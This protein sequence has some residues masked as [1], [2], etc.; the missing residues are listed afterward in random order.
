MTKTFIP[1]AALACVAVLGAQAPGRAPATADDLEIL[2]VHGSI[3]MLAGAGGNITVSA[4]KDGVLVVD[5]GTTESAEKTLAAIQRLQR[6][7]QVKEPPVDLRWGAE[8]RGTLQGSLNPIGPTKPIRYIIN[9]HA[10]PDHVGGNERLSKA[11]RTFTGGNVAGDIADAG[12][13]AAII[14]YEN[15]LNR[16][17]APTGSQA[18]S[19]E[20]AWPTDTFHQASMKLSHF[21]NGDAVQIFHAAN[22]HTDGDSLVYFRGSDVISAGDLFLMT[23]YPIIDLDRGGTINGLIDGLNKMLD[24]VIPEFRMEGG[25]MVVPGHGRMSDGADLAYYRDMVTIIRDRID[26]MVKKG[27]TLEQVKAAKPT[28]DYDPRWAAASGPATAEKFIEAAYKTL[29]PKTPPK[30]A[31]ATT[32]KKSQG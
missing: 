2:P 26:A 19:P 25:T 24:I 28:G 14:A 18:P 13:G 6:Q 1:I 4:G 32:K 27:M 3:Y 8:T 31:P 30:P 16:M 29:Q 17:S 9:T 12:Q 7:L 15:V 22:G 21:F 10:H 5:S 11:G 23:T 20:D